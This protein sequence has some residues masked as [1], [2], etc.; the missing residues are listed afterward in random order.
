MRHSSSLGRIFPPPSELW[1]GLGR[2]DS[3][4][5]RR[6][7]LIS[8]SLVVLTAAAALFLWKSPLFAQ[9][10]KKE[11]PVIR[12]LEKVRGEVTWVDSK[13]IS[14]LYE[15]KGNAEYEM[16]LPFDENAKLTRYKNFSDI[17]RGDQVEL[18][19]EKAVESSGT[20]EERT[21]MTVKVVRFLKRPSQ[22][23]ALTSEDNP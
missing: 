18:E 11:L 6:G 1:G 15:T 17:Q 9:E 3:T 7:K 21:S 16:F 4:A 23:K 10:V 8:I 5:M 20:S 12:T 22:D 13:H 14:V 2:G 19:Y